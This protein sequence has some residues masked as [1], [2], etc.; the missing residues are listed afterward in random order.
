MTL[1]MDGQGCGLGEHDQDRKK[2]KEG[3]DGRRVVLWQIYE[4]TGK[5]KRKVDKI[6]TNKNALKM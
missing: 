2:E 3:S 5:I 6:D 4:R 1:T